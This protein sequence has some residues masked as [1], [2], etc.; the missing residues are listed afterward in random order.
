VGPETLD[1]VGNRLFLNITIE[2]ND[3]ITTPLANRS[4]I[5]QAQV[6][7]R[8]GVD[9]KV[10][11]RVDQCYTHRVYLLDLMSTELV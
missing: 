11:A 5:G 1:K 4:Q 8:A 7:R 3:F 10:E 2:D 6:S 9:R